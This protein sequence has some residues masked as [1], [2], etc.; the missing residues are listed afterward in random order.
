MKNAYK[1]MILQAVENCH[2][3]DLLDLVWKL[4]IDSEGAPSPNNTTQEVKYEDDKRVVRVIPN[5]A[6]GARE[7]VRH[8]APNNTKLAWRAKKP[9]E[10]C[11]QYDDGT[12]AA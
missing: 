2:D 9:A 10:V 3:L 1:E 8:T 6:D 11:Y 12:V 7:A 4:L 5:H